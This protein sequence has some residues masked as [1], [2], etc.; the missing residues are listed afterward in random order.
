MSRNPRLPVIE[1]VY[2]YLEQHGFD[3]LISVNGA[4]GCGKDAL[5]PCGQIREDCKAHRFETNALPQRAGLSALAHNDE[6]HPFIKKM[7]QQR[8]L[9][10]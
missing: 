1:I 7:T 6:R 5:A 8:R 2:D 4:C 10:P 9:N 3:G